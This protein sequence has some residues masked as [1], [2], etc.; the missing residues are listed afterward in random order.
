MINLNKKISVSV[1]AILSSKTIEDETTAVE[2][3]ISNYKDLS[4][5]FNIESS[6]ETLS[7]GGIALSLVNARDCIKD[8]IRTARFLKGIQKAL[9]VAKERFKKEKIIIF[10]AGCGPL[11]TL[12]IPLLHLFSSD[13]IE[14]V[15][16]DIHQESINHIEKIIQKLGYEAYVKS[17]IVADAT[18]YKHPTKEPLHVVITETMDR[19]LINEPQVTITRNFS[20]QL[21]KNG[22]LIPQEITVTRGNAFFAKEFVFK[23]GIAT[24][25]LQKQTITKREKLISLTKDIEDKSPFCYETEAISVPENYEEKPDICLYTKVTIFD[26]VCIHN[27][28]S[29]ITN[30]ICL[31]SMYTLKSNTYK[32]CYST[33]NIPKWKL[34]EI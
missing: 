32:L 14:V 10:Y 16:L 4:P 31:T 2:H 5:A 12:V 8:P 24:E 19:A 28:E 34:I 26:D 3:L 21:H 30:P 29:F 1:N 17:Y 23:A 20:K 27:A 15:F 18:T 33:K 11:G 13:D 6:N 25:E 7:N 22:I 9:L